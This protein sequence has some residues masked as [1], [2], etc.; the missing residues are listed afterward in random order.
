MMVKYFCLC[1]IF[2]RAAAEVGAELQPGPRDVPLLPRGVR[3]LRQ[4]GELS[5]V[6]LWY[7]EL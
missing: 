1:Q 6:E 7:S 3:H 4:A 5:L 2:L